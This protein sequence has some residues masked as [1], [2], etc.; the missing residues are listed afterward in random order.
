[1]KEIEKRIT[2]LEKDVAD[3]QAENYLRIEK[4]EKQIEFIMNHRFIE[5]DLAD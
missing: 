3:N 2:G 1:M 5:T 4:L